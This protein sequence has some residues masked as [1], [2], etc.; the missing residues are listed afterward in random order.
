M[1]WFN[2]TAVAYRVDN[3]AGREVSFHGA[4]SCLRAQAFPVY[5]S[6]AAKLLVP[7]LVSFAQVGPFDQARFEQQFFYPTVVLPAYGWVAPPRV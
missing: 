5:E 4:C 3:G 6:V 2:P 1:L 7:R